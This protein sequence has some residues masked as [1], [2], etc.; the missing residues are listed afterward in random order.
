ML[1]FVGAIGFHGNR[2]ADPM[3][4][5]EA[6][7]RLG[8]VG[9]G[10]VQTREGEDWVLGF[11]SRPLDD[12]DAGLAGPVHGRDGSLILIGS[13]RIDCRRELLDTLGLDGRT[14]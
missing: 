1:H 9:F 13:G 7:R 10:D 11:R 12:Y 6:A 3:A 4:A 8:G 14:P 2:P 5:S